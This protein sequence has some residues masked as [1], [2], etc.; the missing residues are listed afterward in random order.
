MLLN[1]N[2]ACPSRKKCFILCIIQLR[3][4]SWKVRCLAYNNTSP[5]FFLGFLGGSV[6]ENS[7]TNAGD[8]GLIPGSRSSSGEENGNSLQCSCLGRP[9]DRGARRATVPG[10]SKESDTTWWPNSSNSNAFPRQRLLSSEC[11][12]SP[13]WRELF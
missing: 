13:P 5:C 4:W 11:S 10:V 8:T 9:V 2:K 3:K 7:A 12:L 1:F 6:V